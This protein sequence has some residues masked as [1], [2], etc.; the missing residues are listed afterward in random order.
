MIPK[1]CKR[2]AEVNFPIAVAL[3][4]S[5]REKFIRYGHASTLHLWCARRPLAV[6][7]TM[8]VAFLL[9]DSCDPLFPATFKA[10]VK[11]NSNDYES[12]R[13]LERAPPAKTRDA[14]VPFL[15]LG[16]LLLPADERVLEA[17]A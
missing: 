9:S 2:L 8:L 1:E 17:Q 16:K 15:P 12:L 14:L 10:T 4:R 13:W 11:G 7:W 5:I 6:C 3:K